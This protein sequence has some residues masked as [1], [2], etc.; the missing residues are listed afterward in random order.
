VRRVGAHIGA[1]QLIAVKRIEFVRM[2]HEK[3]T[4]QHR[5]GRVSVPLAVKPVLAA[6]I[7]KSAFGRNARAAEEYDAAAFVDHRL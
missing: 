6:E 4:A 5:L 7:L 2:R 3:R 1:E